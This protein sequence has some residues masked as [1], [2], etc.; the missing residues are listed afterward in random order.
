M[1][2]ASATAP[3]AG[4]IV[5]GPGQRQQLDLPLLGPTAFA[6]LVIQL[7]SETKGSSFAVTHVGEPRQSHHCFAFCSPIDMAYLVSYCP[8]SLSSST[9]LSGHRLLAV[10]G[11]CVSRVRVQDRSQLPSPRCLCA[12]SG[13]C[14]RV[15]CMARV[16][17]CIMARKICGVLILL[18]CGLS[19]CALQAISSLLASEHNCI[20][21]DAL[22]ER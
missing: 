3:F 4:W 13:P 14:D 15:M 9:L 2:H 11:I 6:V 5:Q 12:V 18:R 1:Q 16:F 21:V 17:A 22:G 19:G 20:A 7:P 8:C 10:Y